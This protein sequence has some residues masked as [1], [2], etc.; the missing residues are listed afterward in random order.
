MSEATPVYGLVLDG[1]NHRET[2]NLVY[3]DH[4]FIVTELN[5]VCHRLLGI[6]DYTLTTQQPSQDAQGNFTILRQ[7]GIQ[8]TDFCALL[9]FLRTGWMSEAAFSSVMT[10]AVTLGGFPKVDQFIHDYYQRKS[11][12]ELSV[13]DSPRHPLQDARDQYQWLPLPINNL[14]MSDRV[15]EG[16]TATG[17]I[18]TAT[19]HD[20]ES[21][22]TYL[23]R[24]YSSQTNPSQTNTSQTNS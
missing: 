22:F 14:Y 19:C 9:S 20:R 23:R 10:V 16:Y 6:G 13:T 11:K 18:F 12:G 4:N 24:E 2:P 8:R 5:S 1:S 3:L 15:A 21:S 17:Y 7:L